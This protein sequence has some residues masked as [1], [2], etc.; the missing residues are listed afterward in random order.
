MSFKSLAALAVL[1]MCLAPV[2]HAARFENMCHGVEWTASVESEGRP[3]D[4]YVVL[5]RAAGSPGWSVEHVL[6]GRMNTHVDCTAIPF[7]HRLGRFEIS[8]RAYNG[9]GHSPEAPVVVSEHYPPVRW[10]YAATPVPE[11]T[12]DPTPDPTPAPDPVPT[13]DPASA[14]LSQLTLH[15]DFGESPPTIQADGVRVGAEVYSDTNHTFTA[16]PAEYVG[17]PYIQFPNSA[18]FHTGA[19]DVSVRLH[20]TARVCIAYDAFKRDLPAWLADYHWNTV[21]TIQTSYTR[22][23]LY[24]QERPAGMVEFGGNAA[25][26]FVMYTVV[27]VE[28]A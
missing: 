20:R 16:V 6:P 14:L 25:P 24:C 2:A 11:P 15:A 4:G 12:P 28:A 3:V 13:P 10:E 21:D 19:R 1:L 9:A 27:V 17:A 26:G 5:V 22:L 7:L 8:V 18:R 23:A